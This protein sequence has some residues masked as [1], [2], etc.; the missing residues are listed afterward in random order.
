LHDV[1]G[2]TD[3]ERSQL[4]DLAQRGVLLCDPAPGDWHD[5]AAKEE[6][7]TRTHWAELTA[8]YH[9]R[10]RW[11]GK[12]VLHS[13]LPV[14]DIPLTFQHLRWLR[15]D[16]PQH[17]VQRADA[18]DVTPLGIPALD[19]AFFRTLLSRRTTR[20]YRSNEALPVAM[21]E[22]V[23]YVV[24]GTHGLAQLA[25]GVTAVK[26]SSPSGGALHPVEAYVLA[27][28]VERIAPGLYHYESQTHGLARLSTLDLAAARE[29]ANRFTAGQTFFAEAHALVIQV[30]RFDRNFWKY[31][32]DAKA[33]NTILMDA[34][35][36]SQTFYLAATHLGL[37]AFYTAAINDVDIA[38]ALRLDP[39]REAPLGINGLG[40][41]DSTRNE[42]HF[43]AE[44]YRPARVGVEPD[45][46]PQPV[47]TR[48]EAQ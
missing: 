41:P 47:S 22:Q 24:F 29:L 4:L 33:Y 17:F 25:E 2:V 16:A 31:G 5:L 1:M 23:L 37:G 13:T 7:L 14:G 42:L 26:R 10:T 18:L 36:L 35:H 32:H 39:E 40:I 45:I 27:L 34:G 11:Q 38:Q 20:A 46:E 12:D 9:A 30:A 3:E 8:V 43:V 21:L 15:G 6:V 48:K 28:N 44:P 19:D